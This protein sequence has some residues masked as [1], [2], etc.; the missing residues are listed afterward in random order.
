MRA[1][2]SF[3][4][5]AVMAV[6]TLMIVPIMF[7]YYKNT[8]DMT[9]DI[10][11]AVIED[12]AQKI[13][14]NAKDVDRTVGSAKRTVEV[15]L[16]PD[17]VNITTENNSTLVFT[18]GSGQVYVFPTTIQLNASM[19]PDHL[20]SGHFVILKQSGKKTL[21]LCVKDYCE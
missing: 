3:E 8:A 19:S 11:G 10:G 15:K 12:I 5:L 20:Y 14:S 2:A 7:I 1:Q 9:E 21:V 18:L 4:Y 17:V 16:P 6:M 13:I